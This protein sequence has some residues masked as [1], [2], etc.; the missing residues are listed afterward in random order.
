LAGIIKRKDKFNRESSQNEI[1]CSTKGSHQEK[2][3][4]RSSSRESLTEMITERKKKVY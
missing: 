3:K 4:Q 1:R 2:I